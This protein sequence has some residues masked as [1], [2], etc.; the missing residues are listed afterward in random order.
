MAVIRLSNVWWCQFQFFFQFCLNMAFAE[1]KKSE[2]DC[3]S[4]IIFYLVTFTSSYWKWGLF[5]HEVPPL[6]VTKLRPNHLLYLPE[7]GLTGQTSVFH[8]SKLETYS[9]PNE[10]WGELFGS[11]SQE[12]VGFSMLVPRGGAIQGGGIIQGNT[13]CNNQCMFFFFLYSIWVRMGLRLQPN[14]T[15]PQWHCSFRSPDWKLDSLLDSTLW[16]DFH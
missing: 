16:H 15:L 7:N 4:V 14:S 6:F 12:K 10:L 5:Y 9:V 11:Y 8:Q 13:V 1:W 2:S 3:N